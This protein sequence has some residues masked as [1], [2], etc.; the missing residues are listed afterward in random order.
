VSQFGGS[1][2]EN[3][4]EQFGNQRRNYLVYETLRIIA[5]FW[6]DSRPSCRSGVEGSFS[7][8]MREGIVPVSLVDA[9]QRTML[10]PHRTID[11]AHPS[12]RMPFFHSQTRGAASKS[13]LVRAKLS[14]C[15][16]AR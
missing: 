7:G 12:D 6:R 11:R 16:A 5:L 1:S 9:A 4:A 13:F 10:S 3:Y 15:D 14:P 2:N 8:R